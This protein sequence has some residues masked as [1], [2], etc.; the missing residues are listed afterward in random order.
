V[1]DAGNAIHPSYV[2]GQ[3]QGGASQGI[4]W[5][6]NEEYYYNND[7]H[8][9]NSSLLDYR[10]PTCLD[11]PMIDTVI[12]EVPNPAHPF[13]VRGVGEVSVVPP[14]AAI[15]NAIYAAIGIRLNN[16]PMSPGR[17]LEAIWANGGVKGN[18]AA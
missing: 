9:V 16:L 4:G 18:G 2:E 3:M 15:S 6:L 13:G 17:V 7:G 10:M 8:M 11:L 14:M 12:V 5:A 1:Q